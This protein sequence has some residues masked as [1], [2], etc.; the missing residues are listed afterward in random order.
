MKLELKDGTFEN[1]L[2]KSKA[3]DIEVLKGLHMIF[4]SID[5]KLSD[6]IKQKKKMSWNSL[7]VM[8]KNY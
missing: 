3:K 6:L 4:A 1:L 2:I 5:P 8:K 7:N